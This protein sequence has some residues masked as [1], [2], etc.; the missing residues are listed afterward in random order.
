[1]NIDGINVA[2]GVI[3]FL[4]PSIRDNI[5][6]KLSKKSQSVGDFL[7]KHV[8]DYEDLAL[9]DDNTFRI[10][11]ENISF[12]QRCTMF[13]ISSEIVQN[14]MCDNMSLDEFNH[15]NRYLPSIQAEIRALN[16][17][18]AFDELI[19]DAEP[20]KLLQNEILEIVLEL[21]RNKKIKFFNKM[22]FKPY[23]LL[24]ISE[25]K[26][27]KTEDIVILLSE[28]PPKAVSTVLLSLSP[29]EAAGVLAELDKTLMINSFIVLFTL[30]HITEEEIL[31][32][33]KS[34]DFKRNIKY[35]RFGKRIL[36]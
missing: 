24:N 5:I 28:M 6:E 11:L 20:N 1:M 8:I 16:E 29:E 23:T 31:K 26:D 3:Q 19:M 12:T 18:Y 21:M 27:I 10:I 13:A 34:L 25:I 36:P 32:V 4:K 35:F 15:L 22:P 7:K 9:I 33:R 17:Y 14:K 30:K 2:I